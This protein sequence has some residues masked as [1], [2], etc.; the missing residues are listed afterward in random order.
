MCRDCKSEEKPCCWNGKC[1]SDGHL[2]LCI[3]CGAE[4]FEEN[5]YW[6]HHSQSD[7]PFEDRTP[8][9]SSTDKLI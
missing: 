8:Q 3:C 5:G 6:F 2:G 4:M 9:Y 1:Q 7:I